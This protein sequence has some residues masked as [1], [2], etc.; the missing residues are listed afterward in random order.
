MAS[1]I[2]NIRWAL[3]GLVNLSIDLCGV[4]A[5]YFIWYKYG[6]VLAVIAFIFGM[7][8]VVALSAGIGML[9]LSSKQREELF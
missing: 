3:F 2:D 9:F 8:I 1:V 7:P 6:L 4:I 5:V